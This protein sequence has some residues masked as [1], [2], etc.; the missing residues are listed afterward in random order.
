MKV[1]VELSSILKF[2]WVQLRLDNLTGLSCIVTT[3]SLFVWCVA[4]INLLLFCII[5]LF[6]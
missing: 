1:M 4:A 3:H 5:P 6:V 2:E